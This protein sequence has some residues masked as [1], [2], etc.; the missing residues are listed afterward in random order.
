MLSACSQGRLAPRPA[1]CSWPGRCAAAARPAAVCVGQHLPGRYQVRLPALELSRPH[2]HARPIAYARP[3]VAIA[4]P[5]TTAHIVVFRAL[6]QRLAS[7]SDVSS[8]SG[9]DGTA[10]RGLCVWSVRVCVHCGQL[11]PAVP[12]EKTALNFVE[13]SANASQNAKIFSGAARRRLTA[14]RREKKLR[15]LGKKCDLANLTFFRKK[16]RMGALLC[17]VL[18]GYLASVCACGQP[19]ARLC[20]P[21]FP[22]SLRK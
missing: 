9:S 19:L 8:G 16:N 2:I 21:K 20:W 1:R 10:A 13:I 3:R 15:F 18:V 6:S 12:P 11:E 4:L 14:G 22:G 7:V 17:R 5:F